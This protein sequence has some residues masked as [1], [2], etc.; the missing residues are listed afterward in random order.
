MQG[1]K[2]YDK[3]R[4]NDSEIYK[5][6]VIL[7]LPN[8]ADSWLSISPDE[9]ILKKAAYWV[10]LYGAP[11][12]SNSSGQTIYIPKANLLTPLSLKDLV[13]LAVNKNILLYTQ[14]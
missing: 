1:T 12:S 10:C 11:T 7:F 5:I 13:E 4:T 2:R 14:P 3:L 9:L 8:D 6:L